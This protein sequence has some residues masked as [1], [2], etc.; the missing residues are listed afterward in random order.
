MKYTPQP[1][2]TAD[3]KLPENLQ[4]LAEQMAKN[5]HEVWAAGRIA[6]GW[7]YGAVRDDTHKTHPC[8]VPYENLPEVE[9]EYDRRTSVETLKFILSQ[10][11]VILGAA[12]PSQ[13]C[14]GSGS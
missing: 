11:F 2:N 3:I 6:D 9:K 4:V 1:L 5:V 13:S 12:D 7:T 14:D 8:L 10:G